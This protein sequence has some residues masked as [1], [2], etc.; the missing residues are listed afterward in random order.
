MKNHQHQAPNPS[1]RLLISIVLNGL[2]TLIEIVGGILSNSLALISDAIHN[3]SD[4]LA[5]TL[6]WIA[7][8]VGKR[9]PDARR[10]FGYKRFEILSAFINAC[11]LTVISIYL[12]YEAVLRFLHPEPV[13]SGLML[14]IAVIGLFANLVSMLFLHRDSKESLNVKAA[15]IHLLG[16]TLS[17]VAVIAGAVL[18]YYTHIAWIDPMLTVII[19]IVIMVQGYRILQESIDI[20]MQSTPQNLDLAEIKAMLEKHPMIRN[21]HHVHCWQLQDHNILFEAHMETSKDLL[22]SDSGK[23]VAEIDTLLKEKYH[24]THTTLQVEFDC[25]GDKAMIKQPKQ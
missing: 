5:L 22:L 10:T 13:K 3:L 17:S 25:C 23:L 11:V 1:G 14:L 20:L 24:I 18:I 12:I 7:N 6:A 8:R 19:S 2:I 15:Y 16:D 4:T 9:K 21:I